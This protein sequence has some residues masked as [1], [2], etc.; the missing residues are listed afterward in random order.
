MLRPIFTDIH[1]CY[2]G[3]FLIVDLRERAT[4]PQP[5]ERR[6]RGRVGEL[7]LRH[8][9]FLGGTARRVGGVAGGRVADVGGTDV[10]APHVRAVDN[11][12]TRV[13]LRQD[14]S[15]TAGPGGKGGQY[16]RLS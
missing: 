2:D 6:A 14:R 1:S 15:Q 10:A 4:T 3:P 5:V 9:E 7:A 13:R 12:P 16:R 11:E 8:V